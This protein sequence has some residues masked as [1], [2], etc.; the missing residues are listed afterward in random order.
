MSLVPSSRLLWLVIYA[1]LV[2]VGAGPLPELTPIWLLALGA[3]VLSALVD[4]GISLSRARPPD[5]S[6]PPIA[7]FMRDREGAFEITFTNPERRP[8]RLRVAIGLPPG[9][10]SHDE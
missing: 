3:A 2:G 7:R 8:R 9:F 4:A 5:V 1:A 10:V 6:L